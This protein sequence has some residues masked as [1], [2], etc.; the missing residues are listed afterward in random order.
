MIHL[1]VRTTNL[2][3]FKSLKVTDAVVGF[4]MLSQSYN[5][6]TLNI[7]NCHTKE[8]ITK[9]TNSPKKTLELGGFEDILTRGQGGI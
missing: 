7:L 8:G 2:R 3:D 1:K 5:V 9:K 6:L 4:L